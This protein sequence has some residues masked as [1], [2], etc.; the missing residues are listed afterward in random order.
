MENQFKALV[1]YASV[2]SGKAQKMLSGILERN[3]EIKFDDLLDARRTSELDMELV[4]ARAEGKPVAFPE[5]HDFDVLLMSILRLLDNEGFVSHIGEWDSSG[6]D[7][8]QA[9]AVLFGKKPIITICENKKYVNHPWVTFHSDEVYEN[10]SEFEN[11]FREVVSALREKPSEKMRE[12]TDW[13]RGLLDLTVK[14]LREKPK[15]YLAHATTHRREVRELQLAI[16]EKLGEKIKLSNPYW[17]LPGVEEERK[18]EDARERGEII[19]QDENFGDYVVKKDVNEILD[20]DGILVFLNRSPLTIGRE[21]ELVYGML[22]GK[23]IMFGICTDPALYHHPLLRAHLDRM[24]FYDESK[25]MNEIAE[26]ASEKLMEL[27]EKRRAEGLSKKVERHR[28]MIR[29]RLA[30]C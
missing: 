4:K 6:G 16:E 19:E 25:S 24:E 30:R 17:D 7:I 12:R 21:Q 18:I 23:Q 20:A 13:A 2:E 11:S 1:A 28:E 9:Y 8:M 27:I 29:E 10:S 3:Q 26:D 15:L 22:A 14:P 5:G